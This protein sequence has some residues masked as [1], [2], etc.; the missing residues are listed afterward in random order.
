MALIKI[1]LGNDSFQIPQKDTSIIDHMVSITIVE[2]VNNFYQIRFDGDYLILHKS[3]FHDSVLNKIL[4]NTPPSFTFNQLIDILSISTKFFDNIDLSNNVTKRIELWVKSL[5]KYS[6]T[7]IELLDKPDYGLE[8]FKKRFWPY[9][10]V[11]C[12]D[13]QNLA[14]DIRR[15][16]EYPNQ[17]DSSFNDAKSERDEINRDY[18]DE[19]NISQKYNNFLGYLVLNPS[20]YPNV[21]SII[22]ILNTLN[23]L[24]LKFLMFESILRLLITPSICHI[25]KDMRI[26]DLINPLFS[27]DKK[28]KEIFMHY[29]YYAMYILNHEDTVM[30]S[31]IRRT[32]RIIFTHMEAILMPISYMYHI[33]QDPY[34]QQITGDVSIIQSVPY[35]LRCE[36][37]IH[38]IEVFEKRFYLA[39]GGA[40]TNIHLSEY[41]AAV[42]GSI[43]VPCLAYIEL[44]KYFRDVRFNTSR[45]IKTSIKYNDNLYKP[46]NTKLSETEKDFMSYLEYYYPS[47]HSLP[48][49]EFEKQ[50]L[51]KVDEISKN[52][53]VADEKKNSYDKPLK[54]KYNEIS[55]IDI[56]ISIDNYE[57]FEE[58]A[59][60]LYKQIKKNCSHI[61]SVWIQKV[62]T[63]SSFK[64]KIYGPGLIRPI[65]MFRVSYGPD[66]M[67][68]KFHCPIVRSWYDGGNTVIPD[69]YNH[70]RKIKKYWASKIE[71]VISNY[72]E[73][74]YVVNNPGEIIKDIPDNNQFYK[75]L[76][77][78]NSCL[79]AVL[80]GV[81]NNYKWFF[82]SKPCV[83]VILKIA[84]RG[85]STILT[86][87]EIDALNEYMKKSHRWKKFISPN[88]DMCGS[89]SLEHIMFNPCNVDSG[90]RYKLR[91]FKKPTDSIYSKRLYVGNLKS[92]TEYDIDL[93]V[94]NNTKV[95]LPDTIKINAFT[96]YMEQS[97]NND[98]S[99]GESEF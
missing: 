88:N 59:K 93:S 17:L 57:T 16:A 8:L 33:E 72:E 38:A 24:N 66:K 67:V 21:D 96:E 15:N 50:V 84:Q 42:S 74:E 40:L 27:S 91:H 92:K 3:G 80:S 65:D 35:Y 2:S 23:D 48:D 68:K 73:N 36:R 13:W 85:Y 20:Q 12:K 5:G 44:E 83:E 19:Y 49:N 37:Y 26:W 78:I 71:P 94:K 25:V 32:Y 29:F 46:T 99:D 47:Y 90:I 34:I 9:F 87:Q 75:G 51:T 45:S 30:F 89:M 31:Q 39:T 52:D 18:L 95:Y 58:I 41:K 56:S 53:E 61:G 79:F 4:D 14:S 7:W 54:P 22:K 70:I 1:R 28:Y 11:E 55:D 62:Y 76:N 86:V 6:Y 77:I 10:N 63:A 43:L 82:N 69:K 97:H 64:F 60:I 81:N 98:F